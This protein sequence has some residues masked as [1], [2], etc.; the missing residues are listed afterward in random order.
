MV[1]WTGARYADKPTVEVELFIDA[2]PAKVWHAIADIQ[3]MPQLSDE[4]QRVQWVDG[5]EGPT[6][7]ARFIGYNRHEA[8]GEWQTTSTVTECDELRAF[9]WTV[10]DV[11][12]PGAIWSFVLEPQGT[13]TLLR[14]RVQMGPGRS[15]LNIAIDKM[16]EK[17]QK[18]VFVRLRE[19]ETGMTTNL[20]RIKTLVEA[21][22]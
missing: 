2:P 16:P 19:Y 9:A 20:S 5:A 7:G 14:Q 4:L 10:G 13:G 18:I 15:G 12:C 22:E 21:G 8:L 3:L 17:E 1:E 6:V 11:D